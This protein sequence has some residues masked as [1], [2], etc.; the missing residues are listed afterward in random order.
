MSHV[1]QYLKDKILFY[2]LN[3][4]IKIFFDVFYEGVPKPANAEQPVLIRIVV[5]V[6]KKMISAFNSTDVIYVRSL[7]NSKAGVM[8]VECRSIAVAQAVKSTFAG[9]VK[10]THPPSYLKNVS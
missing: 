6:V 5:G 4:F 10:S 8:N 1:L 9:L 7:R 2:A 3:S